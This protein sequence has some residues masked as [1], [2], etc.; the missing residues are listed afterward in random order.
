MKVSTMDISREK[1]AMIE[2]PDDA[3]GDCTEWPDRGI[4]NTNETTTDSSNNTEVAV[5]VP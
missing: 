4:N 1:G 5:V 2:W 3:D